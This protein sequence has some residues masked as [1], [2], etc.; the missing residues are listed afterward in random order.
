MM[1]HASHLPVSLTMS[2]IQSLGGGSEEI[3][4]GLQNEYAYLV[5]LFRGEYMEMDD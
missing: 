5:P 3:V 1:H 4:E 2:T